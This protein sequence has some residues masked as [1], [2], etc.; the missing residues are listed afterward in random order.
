MLIFY[1]NLKQFW[2]TAWPKPREITRSLV[3][4]PAEV[5]RG[6][7]KNTL[8]AHSTRLCFTLTNSFTMSIKFSLWYKTKSVF[9]RFLY[10]GYIC[11]WC[12][13]HPLK[14]S[15]VE[16]LYLFSWPWRL[17]QSANRRCCWSNHFVGIMTKQQIKYA[18][19]VTG[20]ITYV[21][22]A[23]YSRAFQKREWWL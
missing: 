8:G 21:L 5:G 10:S 6:K 4:L 1:K 11:C 13:F 17:F 18:V 19:L 20:V 7:R 14:S 3:Y 16:L 23:S 22:A 15:D 12:Q 2:Q 9:Y